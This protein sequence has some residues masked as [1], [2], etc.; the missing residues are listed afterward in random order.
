MSGEFEDIIPKRSVS[1]DDPRPFARRWLQAD[2]D[3]YGKVSNLSFC[4]P[5]NA[6]E[7]MH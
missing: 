5:S 2:D 7:V 1:R 4:E 6:A 3:L